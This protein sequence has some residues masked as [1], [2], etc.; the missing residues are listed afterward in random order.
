MAGRID[1]RL[2]E[3]NLEL[4]NAAPPAAN[5]V[6]FVSTGSLL[7]ISG[8][9]PLKDGKL[10]HQGI[11]GGDLDIE[12]GQAAARAC[13][14]GV[15]AQLRSACDGDLD[16]VVRCVQ[17]QGFVRSAPEFDQQPAVINAASDLMVDVFGDAGRHSRFAVGSNELPFGVSV[18]IAAIFEIDT[19]RS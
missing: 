11:V 3:L 1:T 12:Q 18:E 16:R 8:Q 6:P 14:I 5:Y 4:P 9:V 10:A 17:L 7:F 15:L 19:P 13:A 2:A